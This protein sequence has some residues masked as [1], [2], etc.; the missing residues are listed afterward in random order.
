MVGDPFMKTTPGKKNMNWTVISI[1]SVLRNS[2]GRVAST[3]KIKNI[4]QPR[5]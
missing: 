5:I 3:L 2:I 1:A 4:L